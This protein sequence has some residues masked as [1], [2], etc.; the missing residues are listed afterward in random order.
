MGAAAGRR[1]GHG[2]WL[3]AAY[4]LAS[5]V[6]VVVLGLVLAAS[7]RQDARAAALSQGRAQAAV[8]QQMALAPAL[9]DLD[10]DHLPGHRLDPA[11]VQQAAPGDPARGR[12]LQR[13]RPARARRRRHRALLRQR[14]GDQPGR[15]RQHRVPRRG[16]RPRLRGDR[17]GGRRGR[18]RRPR[19]RPA[20]RHQRR[21]GQ[22]RLRARPPVRP[23]RGRAP[24][25]RAP[26]GGAPGRRARR[27]V[28]GARRDRLVD[29]QQPASARP[30]A[31]ARGAPRPGSPACRTAG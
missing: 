7:A 27:H 18:R 22:R 3:Y 11:S 24:R 31:R 4:A 17:A 5:L 20:H 26:H 30:P 10:L 2:S 6:T 16:G 21:P 13:H 29:H 12:Q 19:R 9:R 23:V 8:I 15:D 14:A 1:R 28:P 25:P